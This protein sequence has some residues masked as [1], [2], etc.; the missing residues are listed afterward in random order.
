MVAEDGGSTMRNAEQ[1]TFG[2]TGRDR[3][4]ALR[5]DPAALAALMPAARFLPLWRGRILF[6]AEG[7]GFV[8]ADHALLGGAP[9]QAGRVRRGRS[10]SHST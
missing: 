10:I 6:S 4:H 8:A 3:A 2:G 9:G 7:L 1:V 5:S